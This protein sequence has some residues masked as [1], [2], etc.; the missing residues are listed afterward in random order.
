[1]SNPDRTILTG[2][3][4]VDPVNGVDGAADVLIDGG[5]VTRVGPNLEIEPGTVDLQV[6]A[7]LWLLVPHAPAS[8]ANRSGA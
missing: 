3:R 8:G 5:R 6:L 2:G 7:W 4:V 1:M